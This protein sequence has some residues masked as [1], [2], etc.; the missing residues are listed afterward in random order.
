[1]PEASLLESPRPQ[2]SLPTSLTMKRPAEDV[3]MGP[4]SPVT[5]NAPQHSPMKLNPDFSRPLMTDIGVESEEM[6]IQHSSIKHLAFQPPKKARREDSITGSEPST[7]PHPDD[8]GMDS[9]AKSL[10]EDEEDPNS[11]RPFPCVWLNGMNGMPMTEAPPTPPPYANRQFTA[12]SRY[13]PPSHVDELNHQQTRQE[14]VHE[15]VENGTDNTS[16]AASSPER[17]ASEGNMPRMQHVSQQKPNVPFPTSLPSLTP[18]SKPLTQ[19]L[20]SNLQQAHRATPPS[21]RTPSTPPNNPGLPPPGTVLPDGVVYGPENQPMETCPECHKQFKRKVY[22]QRHMEREHWSTAK[23]FKCE[24]CS[25]ETKHQSNLSVHRRI[26][27][28][29]CGFI[30]LYANIEKWITYTL[31]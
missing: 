21:P 26:H 27:T 20:Q 3:E 16:L 31:F 18:D 1:M 5:S 23:V 25:Y 17:P 13:E 22:L 4:P 9:D 6:Q 10:G 15:N 12:P 28:G 29:K 8:S 30:C 11:N 7:S 24:D 2:D 14:E 19:F